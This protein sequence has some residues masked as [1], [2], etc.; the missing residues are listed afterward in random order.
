MGNRLIGASKRGPRAIPS[1]CLLF[2]L[3]ATFAGQGIAAPDFATEVLPIFER[4]C[5]GCH[6][7]EKQRS[8]Y[9]LDIRDT[10]LRGG[11]S[12]SPAIIPHNAEASPLIHFVSGIDPE[13]AMPPAKSSVPPLTTEEI[14]ILR[15]W[16]DAGPAWPDELAGATQDKAP[17]WSLQPL[18]KPLVPDGADNPID[19]FVRASLAEKGLSPSPEADRRTL[20]RR[21]YYDLIGMPPSPEEVEAFQSDPDPAAYEKVVDALLASP[22]H[23]ERWARHWL[24]TIHFADSHGYEHDIGRDN[25]WRYRDY[26]IAS[27]NN[28]T[29]WPRFIR[30]QLAADVLYPDEPHLIP[31]LGFLGAGTFDL[32][33]YATATVTFD[34]LDRD[35]LVTQVMAALVSTTANCARCHAHKFDPIS[36]EDYYAL[37]AVFSGVL[38]GDIPYDADPA[39]AQ[40]RKKWNALLAACD[41]KDG[42]VLLTPANDAIVNQWIASRGSGAAWTPLDV[43]TFLTFNGTSQ[44]RENDGVILAYGTRPEKDTYSATATTSLPVITAL[45]LEVLS[46]ETLPMNGPGRNDNGNFHLSEVEMLFFA[47]GQADPIKIKFDSATADFNQADWDIARAIDGK[48]DTAWGIHPDVGKSHHAVFTL[49]EPLATPPGAGIAVTLKQLHGSGHLIGAYRLSV[50]GDAVE[51]AHALPA[52][53]SEA[54]AVAQADRSEAQRLAIASHALREVAN[55]ALKKLPEQSHVF[56]AGTTVDIPDGEPA[57]MIRTLAEPKPV[58]RLERGD[59]DKPRELIPPG[60]LS[61]LTHL[62]GRFE[63]KN[64]MNEGERRA[65][66]AEWFAHPDNVLT[67]RSIVNRVWQFHFGRGICDTPSDFGRMGG[68]PSHPALLDYLA[69]WFR[70]DAN[71]SLKALHRL[72]VTSATYRQASANRDDAAEVDGGNVFLWRQNRHRIDADAYRD[73]TFTVSGRIDLTMGGPGV[74]H[75]SQSKGPQITPALDYATYDWGAENAPRRSIYRYVWRGIADPFM[76]ALDFPDLGLLSPNRAFSASSLQSLALYNNDF[77]LYHSQA[78]ASRVSEERSETADQIARAVELCWQRKP[79]ASEASAF[80]AHVESYGLA[81]LC[82]VLLN[83]NEYLFVD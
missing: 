32:S 60:A 57:K 26:V 82:R 24:D 45:R 62:P 80:A 14:A 71:G 52:A 49:A 79:S 65:A 83:S 54:L 33:T 59:F 42:G 20:I 67:W 73:Y 34:Y 9:R 75:F 16:I 56:A 64:P 4:S 7:P 31:A 74:Q 43:V 58:H 51:R 41:A 13:L 39:I 21:L 18:V 47:P 30:E 3:A 53:V 44:R 27:L 61:V 78:L 35:D 69:T 2:A 23:G 72:I 29:P 37:Q 17:H 40:E 28:D 10:A 81:A 63:L 15:A 36:Q 25:A 6:G 55:A 48:E 5:Y 22:R 50:T 1:I 76:E 38:K 12:G 77:V 68:M 8:G 46:D 11:D 66:L 19:A 70:D